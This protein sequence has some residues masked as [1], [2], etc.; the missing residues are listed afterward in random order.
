[1]LTL[2]IVRSTV[3]LQSDV[4]DGNHYLSLVIAHSDPD[5]SVQ[6]IS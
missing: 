3:G 1:M 5:I 2:V 4:D 6:D